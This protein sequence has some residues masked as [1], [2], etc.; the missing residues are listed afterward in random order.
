MELREVYHFAV[1]LPEYYVPQ[2]D[3]I[4]SSCAWGLR[5]LA[6]TAGE[7]ECPITEICYVDSEGVILGIAIEVSKY[8]WS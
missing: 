3:D 2:S 8:L 7:K 1:L 5:I 6:G 4:Y